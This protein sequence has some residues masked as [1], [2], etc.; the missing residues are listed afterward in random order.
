MDRLDQ[1]VNWGPMVIPVQ[2]VLLV[3]RDQPD[4]LVLMEMSGPPDHQEGR[5]QLGLLDLRETEET[6][7][8]KVLMDRLVVQERPD[9]RDSWERLGCR[10][11][12]VCR[13]LRE[14]PASTVRREL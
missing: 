14:C 6:M 11:K 7:V 10:V 1:W 13:V 12:T 4:R 5:D 2:W 3:Q 9:S 8:L